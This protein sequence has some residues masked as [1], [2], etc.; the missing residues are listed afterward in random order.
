MLARPGMSRS[1]VFAW[2]VL[3][4][5]LFGSGCFGTMLLGDCPIDPACDGPHARKICR[6][7]NGSQKV[8]T[9]SCGTATC[10][11]TS[12]GPLCSASP[13]PVDACV[14]P[15]HTI[16]RADKVC[17]NGLVSY[18]VAG[19]PHDVSSCDSG[20]CLDTVACG[21]VCVSSPVAE[22]P[23][24]TV[25]NTRSICVGNVSVTCG[26]GKAPVETTCPAF[27]VDAPIDLDPREGFC[28]LSSEKDERCPSR[29]DSGTSDPTNVFCDGTT[30]VKCRRKFVIER[31]SCKAC[32]IGSFGAGECG[33]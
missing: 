29:R 15:P 27:C 12:A 21:A 7:A 6:D 10:V 23:A 13:T 16:G 5:A 17:W 32:S 24:C 31:T 14:N 4:I 8:V 2:L 1:I 26:C 22:H 9:E 28:A 3:G 19:Y 25:P 30:L 20:S 18:C 33:R 11:E